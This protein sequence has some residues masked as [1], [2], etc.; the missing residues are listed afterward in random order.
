[1]GEPGGPHIRR[2]SEGGNEGEAVTGWSALRAS[3][4]KLLQSLVSNNPS[5]PRRLHPL[6]PAE[7]LWKPRPVL[8][9]VSGY[10]WDV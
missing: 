5:P 8:T 10:A 6:L 2:G 9:L 3:S 4:P 7:S 1:M